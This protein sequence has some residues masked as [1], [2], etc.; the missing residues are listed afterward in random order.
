MYEQGTAIRNQPQPGGLT[1]AEPW[2]SEE[3]VPNEVSRGLMC[4]ARVSRSVPNDAEDAGSKP[5]R[6]N[7]S[8]RARYLGPQEMTLSL[9]PW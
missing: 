9:T 3:W 6:T 5:G 4:A 8:R 2:L 1:G 7:N